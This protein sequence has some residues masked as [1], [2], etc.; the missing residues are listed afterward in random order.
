LHRALRD[1]PTDESSSSFSD[2]RSAFPRSLD[3]RAY[4]RPGNCHRASRLDD[5]FSSRASFSPRFVSA[6]RIMQTRIV[7]CL[8]S[9]YGKR[10]IRVYGRKSAKSR[11][12]YLTSGPESRCGP[13]DYG[14]SCSDAMHATPIKV[15]VLRHKMPRRDY[16]RP[17]VSR[18]GQVIDSKLKECRYGTAESAGEPAY[19]RSCL[20]ITAR[21]NATAPPLWTEGYHARV[22]TC[23]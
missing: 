21:D 22:I 7:P 5:I 10:Y 9:S 12:L 8:S 19:R 11:A 17:C 13:S 4:D 1:A 23:S 6:G 3:R 16:A 18:R 15:A 2:S 20:L 14:A